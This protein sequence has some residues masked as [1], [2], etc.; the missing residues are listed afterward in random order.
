MKSKFIFQALVIC[1]AGLSAIAAPT[2]TYRTDTRGSNLSKTGDLGL[3]LKVG[4]LTGLNVK[5][6]TNETQAWDA[7]I[8][9]D[10]D[11]VALSIDHLWHF[12]QVLAD[13]VNLRNADSFVPY[14]GVG[15][16]SAFGSKSQFFNHDTESF[17]LALHLPFGF[18]FLPPTASLGLFAEMG[19]GFGIAPT[20]YSFFTADF[21]AR[22]YF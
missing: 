22:F 1:S 20:T 2:S 5:Y 4:N 11:D 19:F 8:A 16:L 17:D 13:K 7:T 15:L 12:K 10:H 18:E 14:L 6:W 3:G 9:F 21:G